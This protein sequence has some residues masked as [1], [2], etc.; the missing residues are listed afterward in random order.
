MVNIVRGKWKKLYNGE[1]R[2][3]CTSPVAFHAAQKRRKSH[4]GVTNTSYV[5]KM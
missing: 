3:L 5:G 2:N 1:L 4:D